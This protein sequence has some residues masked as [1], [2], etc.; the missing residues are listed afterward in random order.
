ML[1][2]KSLLILVFIISCYSK[3]IL[4]LILAI[5]NLLNFYKVSSDDKKNIEVIVNNEYYEVN[6]SIVEK[7]I[8]SAIDL[9]KDDTFLLEDAIIYFNKIHKEIFRDNLKIGMKSK[10]KIVSFF[11][12]KQFLFLC[13]FILVITIILINIIIFG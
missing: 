3:I 8:K 1:V 7:L 10:I 11:T 2:K 4:S 9:A 6:F 12:T 5:L 13:I